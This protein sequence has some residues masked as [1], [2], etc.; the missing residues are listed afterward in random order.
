MAG[1]ITAPPPVHRFTPTVILSITTGG[2]IF[3]RGRGVRG[4]NDIARRPLL[5]F[6]FLV[7]VPEGLHLLW[8]RRRRGRKVK[9]EQRRIESYRT[10]ASRFWRN[11]GRRWR[12]W[13]A[14]G[15]IKG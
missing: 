10:P 1:A 6:G 7:V 12:R 4:D 15:G 8:D 14:E 11:G 5:T 2:M 9:R 13:G 3:V